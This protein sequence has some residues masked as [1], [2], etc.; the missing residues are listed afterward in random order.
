MHTERIGSPLKVWNDLL[1]RLPT[2]LVTQQFDIVFE[3]LDEPVR[4]VDR[5]SWIVDRGSWIVD[6]GSLYRHRK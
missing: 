5:G 4:I 1:E 6:R 3:A 2:D